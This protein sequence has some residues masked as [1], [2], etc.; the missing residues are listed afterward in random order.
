[1]LKLLLTG[2]R[3]CAVTLGAVYF[4][5]QMATAPSSGDEAAKKASLQLVKGESN[6]SN[7]R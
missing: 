2:V 3:L 4:S 1:M 6:R 7:I 5:V